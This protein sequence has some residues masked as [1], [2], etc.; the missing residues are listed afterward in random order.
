MRVFDIGSG[1]PLY[2]V[3]GVVAPVVF[4]STGKSVIAVRPNDKVRSGI[5]VIESRSGKL[6]HFVPYEFLG[7]LPL[8]MALH[9]DGNQL[10]VVLWNGKAFDLWDLARRT[11]VTHSVDVWHDSQ[12]A[13]RLSFSPDGNTLIITSDTRGPSYVWDTTQWRVVSSLSGHT[14]A[15]T[16]VSYS[17]DGTRVATSSLDGTVRLWDTKSGALLWTFIDKGRDP[18]R[19]VTFSSNDLQ[20]M[21]GAHDLLIWDTQLKP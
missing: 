14:D 21:A 16:D 19:S 9:P 8:W 15:I 20:L 4:S 13:K 10:A 2:S 18:V 12:G 6:Q 17:T 1:R 7:N 5:V 3:S 11:K